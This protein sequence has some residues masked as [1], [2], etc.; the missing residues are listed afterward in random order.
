MLLDEWSEEELDLARAIGAGGSSASARRSEDAGQGRREVEARPQRRESGVFGDDWLDEAFDRQLPADPSAWRQLPEGHGI[1]EG[2]REDPSQDEMDIDDLDGSPLVPG[3]EGD[4]DQDPDED[5]DCRCEISLDLKPAGGDGLVLSVLVGEQRARAWVDAHAWCEWI[6]PRLTVQRPQQIPPDLL[7]LLG[8][9]TLLPLQRHA[10]QAAVPAPAFVDAEAGSIPRTTAPTLTLRRADAVM[11]LRLL[12][13]PASWVAALA[14][15]LDVPLAPLE[16]PPLPVALAA[17]WVRLTRRQLRELRPGDGVVLERGVRV[18]LGHAWL[19]AGR[20][21]ARLRVAD[22][23]WCVED[24]LDEETT[25]DGP[26]MVELEGEGLTDDS[27]VLTAVAEVARLP[28]SLD[29]LRGLHRGQ[30]LELAHASHGRVTLTV[31]GHA[32]AHGALLRV[33]DKL[34]MRI[35]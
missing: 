30:V 15:K 1:D 26:G 14:G 32:V 5:G 8:Q 34:V 25:M 3:G 31:S 33:G 18:E 21:V 12:D 6:A 23:T 9:W 22:G 10:E 7:P 4:G 28:L 13:W 29:T 24:R 16:L 19:V 27:I 35:E 2:S 17:G 11:E 20:T